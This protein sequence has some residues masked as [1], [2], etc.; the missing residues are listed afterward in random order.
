MY[1]T[2]GNSGE[3]FCGSLNNAAV[4]TPINKVFA[5]LSDVKNRRDVRKVVVE[6]R[7]RELRG[8]IADCAYER[9]IILRFVGLRRSAQTAKQ[10]INQFVLESE[11]QIELLLFRER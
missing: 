1:E 2:L 3:G 5:L 8:H 11:S 9:K 10:R 6:S 7:V 4:G